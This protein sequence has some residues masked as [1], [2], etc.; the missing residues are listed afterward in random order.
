M[1]ALAE[2]WDK[3]RQT[4]FLQFDARSEAGTGWNGVG[5]G[6]VSVSAPTDDVI[7]FEESGVWQPP[8]RPEIRF[9]NVFR[10]TRNGDTLKLDHLRFGPDRPV[11]L[12]DL[13]I[14]G[15]GEWRDVSPH[16]CRKDCYSANLGLEG[17]RLLVSWS[18]VG[19]HKQE[20]I[21][22]RYW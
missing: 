4:R 15:D 8:G 20:S 6:L 1:A 12:F 3:L 16:L 22:Y 7:V 11:F 5:V 9:N 21:R 14:N 17:D 2:V 10:W 19:P 13:T 18:V